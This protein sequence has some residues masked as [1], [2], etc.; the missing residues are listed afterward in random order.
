[1]ECLLVLITLDYSNQHCSDHM[2]QQ[3]IL[4]TSHTPSLL[5]FCS[6][7]SSFSKISSSSLL[8]DA[9]LSSYNTTSN[10]N[11]LA[12]AAPLVPGL[13]VSSLT[14]SPPCVVSSDVTMG[15][16]TLSA[17]ADEEVSYKQNNI[18]T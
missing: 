2:L 16:S 7:S 11:P 6:N 15:K 3:K 17:A 5:P 1:M 10:T 13:S 9:L 18:I 4:Q 12:V 8:F 14:L